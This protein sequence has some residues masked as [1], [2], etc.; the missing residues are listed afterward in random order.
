LP[1]IGA[2]V[3]VTTSPTQI[4]LPTYGS[5]TDPVTGSLLNLGPADVDLGGAG[6]TAGAGYLLRVGGTFDVDLIG[7]DVLYGVVAASTAVVCV[8]KLRQ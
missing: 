1:I 3:T 5:A 8:L 6:V 4:V 2:R 7:G